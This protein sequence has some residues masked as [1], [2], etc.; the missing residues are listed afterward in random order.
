LGFLGG[1][2]KCNREFLFEKSFALE[3]F[4]E[5]SLVGLKPDFSL[6]LFCLAPG[7]KHLRCLVLSAL[8]VTPVLK[9]FDHHRIRHQSLA[10]PDVQDSVILIMEKH[11]VLSPQIWALMVQ[12][13]WGWEGTLT[14]A[15]VSEVVWYLWADGMS[16][17]TGLLIA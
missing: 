12:K 10:A 14:M 6:L 15:M 8:T 1:F 16:S 13:S 3:Y 11:A 9:L 4:L 17:L 5:Y 2:S 7:L